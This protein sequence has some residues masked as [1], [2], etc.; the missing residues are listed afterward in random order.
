M[1]PSTSPNL[2]FISSLQGG[3]ALAVTAVFVCHLNSVFE[4]RY[5]I[6]GGF[7][8]RV[9]ASGWNGLYFFFVLSGFLISRTLFAE[10]E[11]ARGIRLGNYFGRRVLRTWPVYYCVLP[12][13]L[14]IEPWLLQGHY[15]YLS[16]TQNFFP[17]KIVDPTWSLAVEEQFYVL[18]PLITYVVLRSR[19][20]IALL[21][22]GA[23]GV[24]LL[25]PGDRLITTALDSLIMGCGIGYLDFFNSPRLASIKARPM[26]MFVGG[27]VIVYLPIYFHVAN[28]WHP[29][30]LYLCEGLGFSCLLISLLNPDFSISK[31]LSG[32]ALQFV[33][34]I[35]YPLYLVHFVAIEYLARLGLDVVT[36][37]LSS[38]AATLAIGWIYH[39]L[40]EKPFMLVSDSKRVE[41]SDVKAQ[42]S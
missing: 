23:F 27:L 16:F 10:L 18:A 13:Y 8:S 4:N 38:V 14:I 20:C 31:A 40:I 5:Q 22:L 6:S 21:V 9:L 28:V 35:S 41:N 1:K 7:L 42:V 15:S 24:R 33:G 2:K 37:S 34:R 11:S 12:L 39:R 26:P 29:S 30:F 3:R 32:P 17:F 19:W 25:N 36:F